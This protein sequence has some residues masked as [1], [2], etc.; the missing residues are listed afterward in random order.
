MNEN[1]T[2]GRSDILMITVDM[3]RSIFVKSF[4]NSANKGT[5]VILNNILKPILTGMALQGAFK[6]ELSVVYTNKELLPIE[7]FL[8]IGGYY[9]KKEIEAM[10][11]DNSRQFDEGLKELRRVI[12]SYLNNERVDE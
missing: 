3:I 2:V 10:D 8:L 4:S 12:D 9:G 7:K 1:K 6:N 5:Q 11:E